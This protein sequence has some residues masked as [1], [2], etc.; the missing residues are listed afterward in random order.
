M[1]GVFLWNLS[2]CCTAPSTLSPLSITLLAAPG[3]AS[4][5]QRFLSLRRARISRLPSLCT[6]T[7]NSC[8]AS[9]LV[10]S[11]SGDSSR[12]RITVWIG[13]GG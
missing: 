6:R 9:M 8:I 7:K 3:N 12:L 11:R 10:P 13:A 2:A 4:N 5:D 1:S